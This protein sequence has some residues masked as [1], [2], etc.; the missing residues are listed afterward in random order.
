MINWLWQNG[1]IVDCPEL[2]LRVDGNNDMLGRIE[3]RGPQGGLAGIQAGMCDGGQIDTRYDIGR[4]YL[5]NKHF[6]LA[7]RSPNSRY[8]TDHR[9]V[10]E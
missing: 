1:P 10:F 3:K 7:L 4:K 5:F 8:P 9:L 6:I 2:P